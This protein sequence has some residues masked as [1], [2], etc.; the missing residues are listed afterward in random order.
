MRHKISHRSIQAQEVRFHIKIITLRS[1]G[2][3][4]VAFVVTVSRLEEVTSV[5]AVAT[6]RTCIGT[7]AVR[8]ELVEA[9]ILATVHPNKARSLVPLRQQ[10]RTLLIMEA[11]NSRIWKMLMKMRI[12]SGRQK[13]F[14][15]R[16]HQSRLPTGKQCL[17]PTGL[18]QLVRSPTSSASPSRLPSSRHQPLRSPKSPK[19]SSA[20]RS[21][22][23]LTPPPPIATEIG[24][25]R[26]HRRLDRL[27]HSSGSTIAKLRSH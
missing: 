20:R 7:R 21:G 16:T 22:P 17:H 13:I 5:G 11:P 26:A 1:E 2:L 3:H 12:L 18:S 25:S 15:S 8:V 19:S 4:V 23:Q 14:R 24:L 27:P 9:S 6:T 10:A